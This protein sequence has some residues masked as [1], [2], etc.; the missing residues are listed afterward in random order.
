MPQAWRIFAERVQ[1][2]FQIA[3]AGEGSIQQRIHAVFDDAEHK[4]PEVIARVW[5][6]PIGTV[7][8]LD[9]EGVEGELA[10]DIRSVLMTS[11]FAGGPP[12]D[13][14]QPLRLRLAAG[15]QPPSR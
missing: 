8:R 2:T 13:M 10:V 5:I 9:L 4:P 14:P 11:D 6:T 3:L 7:E 12:L 1:S 15:R